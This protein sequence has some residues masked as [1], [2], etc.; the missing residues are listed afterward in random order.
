MLER[1]TNGGRE[2]VDVLPMH[3][4]TRRRMQPAATVAD[5]AV[6]ERRRMALTPSPFFRTETTTWSSI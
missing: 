3:A 4:R 6:H 5:R 1:Q 2:G